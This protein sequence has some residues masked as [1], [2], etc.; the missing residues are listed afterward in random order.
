M[1][2]TT[3]VTPPVGDGEHHGGAQP[4]LLVPPCVGHIDEPDITLIRRILTPHRPNTGPLPLLQLGRPP[5]PSA[6]VYRSARRERKASQSIKPLI[7]PSRSLIA[8]REAY[9]CRITKLTYVLVEK[10]R[11][12]TIKY[13]GLGG[14]FRKFSFYEGVKRRYSD[15][16]RGTLCN[17]H[18]VLS[19]GFYRRI[20]GFLFSSFSTCRWC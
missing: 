19:A 5:L 17:T 4:A 13:F 1:S 14:V 10:S 18:H 2:G 16:L 12:G 15:I 7:L 6:F 11:F 8:A 9:S 20:R 3:I